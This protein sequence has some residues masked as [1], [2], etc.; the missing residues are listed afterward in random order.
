MADM[1][2]FAQTRGGDDLFD[3]EIIPVTVEE[4][5]QQQQ[6]PPVQ[7]QKPPP[8]PPA[9]KETVATPAVDRDTT[10]ATTDAPP[11][12]R[13]ERR[14]RGRGR[15]G[16]GGRGAQNA[17]PRRSEAPKT[18]T[19]E[20]ATES[21]PQNGEEK[22]GDAPVEKAE[23]PSG[24][25]AATAP[26]DAPRVPAVRGDRSATGGIKKPK[27]TEEE[28]SQRIAAAR[29]NA[30][31]KA[32]AHARAEA[33]QASFMEREKIA[34]KKRR[35]E[36]ANRR[37]MDTERERNRLR[38]L[39]ALGGR[40]WDAD[41]PE[42]QFNSRG[43]RGQFRRGM[44]GGVPGY[45]RRGFED[46]QTGDDSPDSNAS[47]P[48]GHRGRGRGRG[49]RGRGNHRG[50]QDRPS[51]DKPSDTT[52]QPTPVITNEAEFPSLPVAE[53]KETAAGESA[54]A[55]NDKAKPLSPISGATWA[56]EVE[57]SRE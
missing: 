29:E 8:E 20:V 55:S 41:K 48:H 39:E 32:A 14:G 5:Q 18:K 11:R 54:P 31:K 24:E 17:G 38:K 35:E 25:D 46:S 45:T 56:D 51:G 57:A 27:L 16:R 1:D 2:E 50:A 36:R 53:K 13:G 26:A 30:A 44:H 9:A 52:P 21:E 22:T 4:Q 43:G 6:P 15:G 23:Q 7:Q 12:Q 47:Q 3:D 10:P 49:G 42:E 33:D 34:E 40:E 19:E 37:V 28:L